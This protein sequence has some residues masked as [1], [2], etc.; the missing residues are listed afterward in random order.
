MLALD[1]LLDRRFEVIEGFQAERLCERIVNRDAARGLHRFRRDFEYRAFARERFHSVVLWEIGVDV[2]RF[3]RADARQLLL[4]PRNE[5]FGSKQHRDVFSVAAFERLAI[6]RSCEGDND[7]V[8][9][10]CLSPFGS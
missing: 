6:D 8:A 5:S 2:A 4:E 1:A 7:T 3:T 9:L 10:L